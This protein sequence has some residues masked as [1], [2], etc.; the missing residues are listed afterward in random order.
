MG[1]ADTVNNVMTS[2][3]LGLTIRVTDTT[4]PLVNL[5][6]GGFDSVAISVDYDYS[7]WW[8]SGKIVGVSNTL[9]TAFSSFQDISI[10]GTSEQTNA[11]MT[12]AVDSQTQV[13]GAPTFELEGYNIVSSAVTINTVPKPKFMI[14]GSNTQN[15]ITA[16][17]AYNEQLIENITTEN[18]PRLYDAR[19][20]YY[21]A[22]VTGEE[23]I[24]IIPSRQV[25][26]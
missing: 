8:T 5:T 18:D 25:W 19:V 4:S 7:T 21:I 1:Q 15:N 2:E 3:L 26:I 10:L 11:G 17:Y 12:I 16:N 22:G 20:K 23:P 24:T 9:R 6:A 14:H 13:I